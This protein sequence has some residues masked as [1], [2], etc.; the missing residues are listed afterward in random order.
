MVGSY[1]S[2]HAAFFHGLPIRPSM[3]PNSMMSMGGDR[4]HF[5]ARMSNMFSYMAFSYTQ[6]YFG[7]WETENQM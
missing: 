6:T 2:E 5:W 1:V 3:Q 7:Y 4:M